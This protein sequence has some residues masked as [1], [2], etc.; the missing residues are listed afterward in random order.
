MKRVPYVKEERLRSKYLGA[1]LKASGSCS[2]RMAE[3]SKSLE[4]HCLEHNFI[5]INCGVSH[6]SAIIEP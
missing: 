3:H 5:D 1:E 6:Y 2:A 4:R